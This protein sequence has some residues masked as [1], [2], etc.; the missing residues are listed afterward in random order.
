MKVNFGD[1]LKQLRIENEFSQEKL[2][3]MLNISSQY[4]DKWENQEDMPDIESLKSI[5]K[6]FDVT[7]DSLV[8]DEEEIE[9]NDE[10]FSWEI[11]CIFGCIGLIVGFLF[12]DSVPS[13]GMSGI[14]FAA[15]GYFIDKLI[16]KFKLKN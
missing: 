5:G 15:I 9:T 2:G 10:K 11:M 6:F 7:V 13:L 3:K 1:K 8:Y 12:E 14:G 4:I 16:S